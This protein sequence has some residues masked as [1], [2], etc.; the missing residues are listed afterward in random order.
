MKLRITSW[1]CLLTASALFVACGDE[2]SDGGASGSAGAGGT[3]GT[4]VAGGTGGT[5]DAA[6]DAPLPDANTDVSEDTSQD[7]PDESMQEA[8]PDVEPEAG[9]D[10]PCTL[11][12]N[13]CEPGEKC[14]PVGV[15]DALVCRPDGDKSLGDVC[16]TGGI[17]DCVSGMVCVPYSGT[18]STCVSLCGT[19]LPCD[20][21]YQACFDWF[22]ATGSVAGICLGDDCTPPDTGCS[23]GERCTV[24][25][26]QGHTVPACVPAG[27]VPVGQD[28]SVNECEPGAMCVQ[29][30]S[31]QIC[32]AFCEAGLDCVQE[33]LHCVWPW[34]SLPDIGLCRAGCDPVR[35]TGC[36]A[37]EGCYYMDPDEGSTDCFDAGTL[38]EGAD[39]GTFAEM[40]APGLDCVLDPGSTPFTYH[41]RAFC[42]SEQVCPTGSCTTTDATAALKFCMP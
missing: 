8:A 33:D 31:A 41:C 19:G 32:R 1:M 21:S 11:G 25:A 29:A 2:G 20:K 4:S 40:C 18:V 3:G 10:T 9:P 14:T 35:Q 5:A 16:G 27:D 23:D 42:D 15:G 36:E 22:G 38:E 26:S 34:T 17:D 28:C 39:C 12:G 30:G 6:V 24:L 7:V 37:N 13:E